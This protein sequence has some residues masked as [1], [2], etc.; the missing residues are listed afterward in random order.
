[1]EPAMNSLAVFCFLP[2]VMLA[3]TN[4]MAYE[5]NPLPQRQAMD[6]HIHDPVLVMQADDTGVIL[7]VLIRYPLRMPAGH[8]NCPGQGVGGLRTPGPGTADGQLPATGIRVQPA[9]IPD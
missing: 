8:W 4:A 2:V 3:V 1:M 5:A 9:S 7:P 6:I